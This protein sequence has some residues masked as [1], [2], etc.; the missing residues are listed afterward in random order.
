MMGFRAH[1]ALW[2]GAFLVLLSLG[3][4]PAGRA[5]PAAETPSAFIDRLDVNIVN[6]EVF[7]TDK[8]GRAI[9]GLTQEDFELTVDG[10]TVPV[11]NFYAEVE[12]RPVYGAS[13]SDP[14]QES[15]AGA[16]ID[17]KVEVPPDQIL[18][19]VVFVDQTALQPLNRKRAFKHIRRFLS[20][21]LA[22]TDEI[23]VV[24]LGPGLKF[25]TDF[26]T[27]RSVVEKI[28]KQLEKSPPLDSG[29]ATQRRQVLREI[30]NS[31]PPPLSGPS[32][33]DDTFSG[34]S[35]HN[36][37]SMIRAV[38]TSEYNLRKSG[39]RALT[40]LVGTLAGVPGRKAMLHV[41][42]GISTRPGEDLFI[43][44]QNRF[45]E[46]SRNY[47]SDVGSFDLFRD[48]EEL[49][50]RANA[51]KVT[52][53]AVDA[54]PPTFDYGRSAEAQGDTS[55][56]P[57][58]TTEVSNTYEANKRATL[59][60]AAF[61]TGGRRV[62]ADGLLT[63]HLG[64]IGTDFRSFYSLGFEAPAGSVKDRHKVKV[65]VRGREGLVVRHR[66]GYADQNPEQEAA[67]QTMAALI[68]GVADDPLGIAVQ[69]GEPRVRED[70]ARILP[71][72]IEIPFD[73]LALLPVGDERAAT[74]SLFVTVQDKV[75]ATRPVQR[76]TVRLK[77]PEDEIGEAQGRS[78]RYVLPVVF[79]PDDRRIALGVRDDVAGIVSTLRLDPDLDSTQAG[80]H[81]SSEPPAAKNG[82]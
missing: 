24:S 47:Q 26:T 43:A 64:R 27:D 52:F 38:A 80:S 54:Q 62:I 45:Q 16:D 50:D 25:H 23:A 82:I 51:S 31:T 78:A 79:G 15:P 1:G 5:Q 4:A 60:L 36:V 34:A 42:D 3:P 72:E 73:R 66:S 9:S 2:V 18:R 7:V 68:Y 58:V 71:L 55:V 12:N 14:A 57:T 28:L 67:G 22:P 20:E 46:T 37:L 11:S 53:Y 35:S 56:L 6:V 32:E 61:E 81:G 17:T 13:L 63:Q 8:K 39:T 30:Y 77:L 69:A 44:W 40:A 19:L 65:K 33:A 41:S 70:G 10:R 49:A 75:G 48:F 59:E 76:V 74:L 21:G 29:T